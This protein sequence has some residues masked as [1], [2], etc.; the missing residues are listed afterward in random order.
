MLYTLSAYPHVPLYAAILAGRMQ[1]EGQFANG[2]FASEGSRRVLEAI[3]QEHSLGTLIWKFEFW[4][5]GWMRGG[6]FESNKEVWIKEKGLN[7]IRYD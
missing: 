7:P 6:S 2:Y 5:R 4:K 3:T 1:E